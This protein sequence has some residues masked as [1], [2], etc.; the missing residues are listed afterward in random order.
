LQ[1]QPH[2][3]LSLS[4]SLGTNQSKFLSLLFCWHQSDLISFSLFTQTLPRTEDS[5]TLFPQ[6]QDIKLL[7]NHGV[8]EEPWLVFLVF[9]EEELTAQARELSETCVV[10]V[11]CLLQP[12]L[13]EDG[14]EESM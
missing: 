9:Q 2:D 7:L 5:L 8:L 6:L 10:V 12:R 14:I 3:Q 4:N 1:W 11:V 13:G